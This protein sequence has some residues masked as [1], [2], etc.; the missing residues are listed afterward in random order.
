MQIASVF[1]GTGLIVLIITIIVGCAHLLSFGTEDIQVSKGRKGKYLFFFI[2]SIFLIILGCLFYGVFNSNNKYMN[3]SLFLL[4]PLKSSIAGMVVSLTGTAISVATIKIV[5]NNN[6]LIKE[7]QRQALEL[8]DYHKN[9]DKYKQ[10]LKKIYDELTYAEGV[11]K[12]ELRGLNDFL[13]EISRYEH[14]FNKNEKD[15]IDKLLDIVVEI[16]GKFDM[17][18]EEDYKTIIEQLNTILKIIEKKEFEL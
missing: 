18:S 11:S 2:S 10:N 13:I 6:L 4:S 16:M 14:I 7:K 9:G 1:Y 15:A 17:V 8:S 3:W 5:R 12:K